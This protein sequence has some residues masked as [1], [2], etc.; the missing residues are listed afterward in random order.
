MGELSK[1]LAL[2]IIGVV[3]GA[4]ASGIVQ[5]KISH[6]EKEAEL[7]NI[8]QA[9]YY[10]VSGIEDLFNY[11]LNNSAS[12][13]NYIHVLDSHYYDKDGLYY[14]FEKDISNFDSETSKDLYDFYGFVMSIE[15]EQEE[16]LSITQ[17]R[18]N[19][20]N[21]TDYEFINA[22]NIMRTLRAA[23]PDGIKRADKV[24]K[25]LRQNYDANI[26]MPPTIIS[27]YLPQ[28]YKLQ[29]GSV[30]LTI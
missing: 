4:F 6:D 21:V 1:E 5:W 24:K 29:G 11:S 2:L 30:E 18:L 3:L 17:K 23:M 13:P 25:E 8:A 22:Y 16:L 19:E 12:K 20:G 14:V 27:Y 7:R 26:T 10:D 15:S 9:L 28:I